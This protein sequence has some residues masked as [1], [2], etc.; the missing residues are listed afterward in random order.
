MDS[1]QEPNSKF[2]F[3][4][5]ILTPPTNTSSGNHFIKY[6]IR[7][8]PLYIQTPKSKI[9][10]G[11]MKTGK[12]MYFD[13][14]FTN[15]HEEFIQWIE[16]LEIH[17]QKYM[18]SKRE[19]WFDS[20]L[21]E[22]EIESLFPSILKS[23]KLGKYYILRVNVPI[24]PDTLKI[25]DENEATMTLEDLKEDTNIISILEFQGIKCSAR[26]FQIEIETKQILILKPVN[27]FD[28]CI[29]SK[30]RDEIKHEEEPNRSLDYGLTTDQTHDIVSDVV[31][32]S[33]YDLP[34]QKVIESSSSTDLDLF[35]SF[36]SRASLLRQTPNYDQDEPS[37]TR[38]NDDSS[39]S[40]LMS[41]FRKLS[42]ENTNCEQI[43]IGQSNTCDQPV[44]E[45]ITDISNNELLEIDLNLEEV[46]TTDSV[47]LKN[48]NDVYYEMYK[49]A[50]KK[51]KMAKKM[52]LSSYLE[53]KRI[54][55]LYMLDD[56]SDESDID[57]DD[58]QNLEN[59]E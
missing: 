52:A 54:K 21:E 53:A 56:L 44:S 12:K 35:Q 13:L 59:T 41:D 47:V 55:N 36:D 34:D 38:S 16:N 31:R 3:S 25:Y 20:T 42:D 10:Q 23:I 43:H 15:E 33:D 29:L 22:H 14:I 17:S 50:I 30:K 32:I 39:A 1:I 18:F 46:P 58:F 11:I 4:Y 5:L 26:G 37:R 57:E 7:E 51:A 48:R 9:K 28:K 27:I 45:K 40:S 8:N 6:I 49:E 24:L 19:K 2:Q